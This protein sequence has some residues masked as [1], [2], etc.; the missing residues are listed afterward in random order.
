MAFKE[1]N[2]ERISLR[3]PGWIQLNERTS[4]PCSMVDVS[5]G[6][7]RL[8]LPQ[9]GMVPDVFVLRFSMTT[10]SGRECAVRWRQAKAL[11]VQFV[12]TMR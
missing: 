4:I 3:Y 2:F 7:A 6:G 8:E 5:E 11:G 1:R 10:P 12:K 9:P